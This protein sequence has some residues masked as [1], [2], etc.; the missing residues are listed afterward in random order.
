LRPDERGSHKQQQDFRYDTVRQSHHGSTGPHFSIDARR[1]SSSCFELLR[2][3]RFRV[4][5]YKRK[6]RWMLVGLTTSGS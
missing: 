6:M 1:L 3:C 5:S 2:P 4:V